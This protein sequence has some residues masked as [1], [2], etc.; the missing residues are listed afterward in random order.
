MADN[1]PCRLWCEVTPERVL[2]SIYGLFAHADTESNCDDRRRMP[3]A[4][5]GPCWQ[6][7]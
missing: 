3:P 7:V 6:P 1:L 2:E 5:S 4:G